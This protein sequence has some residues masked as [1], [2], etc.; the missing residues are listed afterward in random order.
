MDVA[1]ARLATS[2]EGLALIDAMPRYSDT[3]SLRLTTELRAQGVDAELVAIALTQARLREAGERKCGE[4]ARG[5]LFTQEG[6]EQATRLN[7]AAHHA[8]RYRD[9]GIG[10]VADLTAGLGVDAMAFASLGLAVLAFERDEATA[11]LADH[12]LRHWPDA[13]VVHADSMQALAAGDLDVDGLFADPARRTARG[14]RHDPKDY[15]PP[16]DDVLALAER[17]PALG[18]KVGPAI[19]HDA[20]P[21][22]VEAQWVSVE[23]D[24]VEAA[25]WCGPLARVNGHSA[26]VIAHGGTHVLT[27]STEP[28]DAGELGRYLHEPDGAVIRAGLIGELAQRHDLTLI[29]PSIAYLTSDAPLASPFA[30][31]FRVEDVIPF[32]ERTL[33]AA[34][35]SRGVGAVEIKKRGMDVS[36]EQLRSRLKLSGDAS[37]TV[38]LTRAAG[39]RVAII[40][41][42]A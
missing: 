15:A 9:A 37:A 10:S 29:D 6:L 38:I 21:A 28:A 18:V 1:H 8:S 24:V 39:K 12:N 20:V 23:G 30:T 3:D 2:P 25:L 27:G 13:R 5:M 4:F 7:V 34:L 35:K 17:Y 26:L 41:E 33:A 14:R 32:H 31:S 11:L 42:R 22:D 36:P 40:A 16:L 19:P